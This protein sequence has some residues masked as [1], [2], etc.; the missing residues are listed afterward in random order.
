MA[1]LEQAQLQHQKS[2]LR[3][4]T[5]SHETSQGF[6]SLNSILD[7]VGLPRPPEQQDASYLVGPQRLNSSWNQK[8]PPQPGKQPSFQQ[9]GTSRIPRSV[10]ESLLEPLNLDPGFSISKPPDPSRSQSGYNPKSVQTLAS[11]LN[12]GGLSSSS[13]QNE[14]NG[15]DPSSTLTQEQCWYLLRTLVELEIEDECTKLWRLTGGLNAESVEWDSAMDYAS[16]EEAPAST[17]E[18][19]SLLSPDDDLAS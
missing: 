10:P 16:S 17:E 18:C 9:S 2:R 7:T 1:T 14:P 5:S 8:P 4:R 15:K 12:R 3:G 13:N 11:S 6:V 19:A